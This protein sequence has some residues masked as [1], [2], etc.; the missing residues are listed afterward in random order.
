[1]NRRQFVLGTASVP[2]LP[3]ARVLGAGENPGFHL[4]SVTYNLLKDADLET[5][6]RLLQGAG[7]EGVELRTGHKHG[8]EPSLGKQERARVRQLFA[9]S[10]VQLVSFGTTCEFHSP[11]AA[12]RKRQVEI[13]KDFIQ[14]ARDT[15]AKGIKVRPNGLPDAVSHETTIQNIAGSL[16]ELGDA[17]RAN[18][19]SVWMEVHG[20][21]TSNP[22][23]AAAI[24]RATDHQQVGLCWNSNAEDVIDGSVKTNFELLKPWVRHAHINELANDYPWRELFTLM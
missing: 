14:L 13:G 10:K 20:P 18:R 6:I 4:G 8:V 12:E 22:Q 21:K 1:M 16:R 5:I 23:I 3:S 7:F 2:L 19:I 17:G 11:D 24:M 9:A 15:G